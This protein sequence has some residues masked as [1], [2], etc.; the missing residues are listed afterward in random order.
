MDFSIVIPTRN[1]TRSLLQCVEAAAQL[2]YARTRYEVLVVD[3]GGQED[4]APVLAPYLGRINFVLLRQ[5]NAGPAAARNAGAAS[6][7]G[8]YV[9]FT[10]DDCRPDPG[11]LD[12]LAG[13]AAAHPGCGLGGLTVNGLP[14]NVFSTASEVLMRYLYHRWNRDGS[15]V[16]FLASNNVAF[17]RARFLELRGFDTRFPRAAAEDREICYRWIRHQGRLVYE[18]A[19]VIYHYHAL[20]PRTFLA[21]HFNYGRG[22]YLLRRFMR[23][24]TGRRQPFE[25]SFH[26]KLPGYLFARHRGVRF[27]VMTG[28]IGLTQVALAFGF[29]HQKCFGR[30]PAVGAG[31]RMGRLGRLGYALKMQGWAWNFH[32][33]LALFRSI[34]YFLLSGLFRPFARRRSFSLLCRSHRQLMAIGSPRSLLARLKGF[35]EQGVRRAA[36][37]RGGVVRMPVDEAEP[38]EALRQTV[39]QAGLALKAPRRH[40]ARVVEKGVLLLKNTEQIEAFHRRVDM[41]GLLQEYALV[42]EP[43]WSGYAHPTLLSFCRYPDH[44]VVVMSPCRED[45]LFLERL[46]TNL[47]PISIGASDWVDPR[48]FRPLAGRAKRFDAV[49]I[50]RWTVQKGHHLLFRALRRIGDSTFRVAVVASTD[51]RAEDR[52]AILDLITSQGLAEQITVFEDLPRDKVNEILNE[53]RVNLLLSR[54]EGSNRSLF[55]GFFAGVPGLAFAN[56]I[57]L[58]KTHFTPHTGRLIAESELADALLYFRNH[59]P[60]FNPRPWALA[61]IAPEVTTARLNAELSRLARQQGETWTRDIVAKCNNPDA[62]YYPDPRAGHGLPSLADLLAAFPRRVHRTD[63]ESASRAVRGRENNDVVLPDLAH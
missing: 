53:S 13:R 36:T 4:L 52:D 45:F 8:R 49:L 10:D 48:I 32:P 29:V 2:A 50:A 60:E 5:T 23:E 22:E 6:A 40:G 61:H 15:G 35:V 14:G 31:N 27:V 51:Y 59:Y 44:P 63:A 38:R 9:A 16:T 41:A 26:L 43:S 39:A 55:E 17:P 7:R 56:H 28:L 62:V 19:A 11:W 30:E 57:G 34:A 37:G 3:D 47:H 54:Q 25:P 33:R 21:Q 20:G 46:G 18:P 24:E 1:R 42:L 58:P 12:A